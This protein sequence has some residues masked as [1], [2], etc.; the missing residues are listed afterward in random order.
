M[1]VGV[2]A[3]QGCVQQHLYHLHNLGVEPTRV[4]NEKELIDCER[5]ILPGG[6]SSTI[7]ALLHRTN[8]FE[9]LKLYC[10]KNPCWGICA[11]SILLAQEVIN[12]IQDSLNALPIRAQRNF[13]GSQKDSFKAH[14]KFAEECALNE[15]QVDFIRAPKLEVLSDQVKVLSLHSNQQVMLKYRNILAT[16]FHSELGEDS[17]LH[18]YFISL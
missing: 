16:S 14:I 4:R 1:K 6:E 17:S 11:G 13:Y 12:P 8:L 9:P 10:K 5:L 18:K 3:L 2:L 7:L 15:M